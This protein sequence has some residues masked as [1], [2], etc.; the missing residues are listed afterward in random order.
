[1]SSM[2][3]NNKYSL[4]EKEATVVGL[5]SYLWCVC[6]KCGYEIYSFC[7][8]S[9]QITAQTDIDLLCV[10]RENETVLSRKACACVIM[11]D[12]DRYW[13]CYW[14]FHCGKGKNKFASIK[15]IPP[16]DGGQFKISDICISKFPVIADMLYIKMWVI[17]I[18]SSINQLLKNNNMVLVTA[19][20]LHNELT[21]VLAACSWARH[22][23]GGC[24]MFHLI[25]E[26][27]K[28]KHFSI[29]AY[30]VAMHNDHF[31]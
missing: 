20:P 29:V 30:P 1:M 9:G 15:C 17:T 10:L 21:K 27:N 6:G 11:R 18:L 22:F 3:C 31:H 28:M 7:G 23:G 2:W 8:S 19:G 25:S 13:N 5:Y 16:K 12:I 24:N 14:K 4:K 26:F